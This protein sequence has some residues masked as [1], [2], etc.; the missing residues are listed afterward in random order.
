MSSFVHDDGLRR[1]LTDER[2]EK[3]EQIEERA[4]IGDRAVVAVRPRDGREELG[5]GRI[6]E[7]D[8]DD[9]GMLAQ[10]RCLREC[11]LPVA[12]AVGEQDRGGPRPP[13]RR[14][15]EQLDRRRKRG[16]DRRSIAARGRSEGS[17]H[18]RTLARE[19][20]QNRSRSV[21]RDDAD[22]DGFRTTP[23]EILRRPNRRRERTSRTITHTAG[24]IEDQDDVMRFGPGATH[25]WGKKIQRNAD[26]AADGKDGAVD[27]TSNGLARGPLMPMEKGEAHS[28]PDEKCNDD[29]EEHGFP[30]LSAAT[31][32]AACTSPSSVRL[33]P[34]AIPSSRAVKSPGGLDAFGSAEGM[35]E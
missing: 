15:G 3:R 31:R 30:Q 23:Y 8:R 19:R 7:S 5:V 17:Q 20:T 18:C 2:R 9:S 24:L 1:L 12:P 22:V 6:A 10:R 26:G 27:R 16:I 25:G 28:G 4:S 21:E 35:S 11:E 32:M 29:E 14:G 33:P 34:F 13:I